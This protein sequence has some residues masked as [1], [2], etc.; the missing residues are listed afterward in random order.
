MSFKI[1]RI[2]FIQYTTTKISRRII[3]SKSIGSNLYIT[4]KNYYFICSWVSKSIG[5]NLYTM[6]LLFS[7]IKTGFK[8]HR[9]K[10]IQQYSISFTYYYHVSKSIG[11][12]LY[13]IWTDRQYRKNKFQNPQDQI[14]TVDLYLEAVEEK[15]GFKIH[16]IKFILK[17][18][19][20][21]F[22]FKYV[23][24]S[25]GSNLYVFD[26]LLEITKIPSF[27]IHRIKFILQ[28]N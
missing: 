9:I 12:N 8:I 22:N 26:K 17:R 20:R 10:F 1:H 14:Y 4:R 18:R 3:V 27:K 13:Q 24:K 6:G 5:S 16:R 25:I 28:N 2:K 23:S 7:S 11:S 15:I 19:F 21:S